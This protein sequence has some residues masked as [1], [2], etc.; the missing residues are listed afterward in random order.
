MRIRLPQRRRWRALIY[1]VSFLLILLAIDLILVQAG[2][3]ISVNYETTR[4]TEPRM[5]GGAIDY[6]AALENHYSQGVTRENNMVVPLL[7]ALGPSAQ[8]KS[9]P[10]DGITNRLG[11]P[12][13]A[14]TG[15]YFQPREKFPADR[16]SGGG[17]DDAKLHERPWKAAAHP[18]TAAW[19]TA[20][21]KP[22][23]KLIE[24]SKRTRFYYPFNAGYRPEA[25]IELELPYL[26]YSRQSSRA[27]VARA[28]MR[29]G[30]N[31]VAGARQDLAAAHRLGGLFTQGATLIDRLVGYA[32]DSDA[33]RAEQALAAGGMLDAQQARDWLAASAQLPPMNGVADG[34][35]V[36]ERY[37][38]LDTMQFGARRGLTRFMT[39]VSEPLK[40]AAPP[41]LLGGL[42]PVRWGHAMEA[43]NGWYD[44]IAAA[45]GK[46]NRVERRA[47]VSAVTRELADYTRGAG[48]YLHML[49]SSEWPLAMFFPALEQIAD[50]DDAAAANRTLA[51]LALA[52][53][54][55]R[56]EHGGYPATLNALAPAYLA[57]I[58]NDPFT[59]K[60]FTYRPSAGGYLLYSVGPDLQDDGGRQM[61]SAAGAKGD[62]A[63]VAGDAVVATQP[64]TTA[65]SA[66]STKH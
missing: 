49:V 10:R 5:A 26:L 30:E 21:E 9:Q 47:A 59:D 41:A 6:L 18:Q 7:E 17:D 28:M 2:R 33:S 43:G 62:L 31:D 66:P 19:L 13:L 63:V 61:T 27:L 51:Q 54:A 50:R 34:I 11:I 32:I 8:A 35:D 14:E 12:S 39:L 55:H 46:T 52:L 15:D 25:L 29:M 20:N 42:A 65:P 3:H 23:A 16:N 36:S 37:L 40:T 56:A 44:R 24:A 22:L 45:F 60:P 1:T 53:A 58:P 64:A 38:Y 48:T 57:T 4:V